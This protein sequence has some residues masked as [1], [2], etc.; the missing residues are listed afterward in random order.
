VPDRRL[1]FL[2]VLLLLAALPVEAHRLTLFAAAEGE[3]IE[4]RVQYAGGWPAEGARVTVRAPDGRV[5]AELAADRMGRFAFTA[6]EGVDHRLTAET[7]EGHGADW[8]V[9]AAELPAALG[10]PPSGTDSAAAPQPPGAAPPQGELEAMIE[11]AVARQ[12]RPLREELRAAGERARLT[13]VLGGIGYI[14]GLAG[15]ALWW[16]ARRWGPR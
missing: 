10:A 13:D 4:G 16:R 11:R 6:T 5:L 8:T 12:V 9:T 15:L 1:L 2:P 3:R 7:G 14:V